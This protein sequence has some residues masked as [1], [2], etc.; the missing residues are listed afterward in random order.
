MV[1]TTLTTGAEGPVKLASH[2]AAREQTS[3][4]RALPE[5]FGMIAF[6]G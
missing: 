4:L 6:L 3:L 5:A 1:C 2:L